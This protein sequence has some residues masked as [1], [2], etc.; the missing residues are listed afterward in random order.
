M[1]GAMSAAAASPIL[2]AADLCSFEQR[3]YVIARGAISQAQAARTAAEAWQ[4][5][6]RDPHDRSTWYSTTTGGSSAGLGALE[7]GRADMVE[8]WYN[9]TAPRVHQA[10]SQLW[11]SKRLWCSHDVV[12]IRPPEETG[13]VDG[14]RWEEA[15]AAALHWD[16]GELYNCQP[17]SAHVRSVRDAVGPLSF[18][19][20]GI[21]Y[22][23]DTPPEHGALCLVP[24]FHRRLDGWLESLPRGSTPMEQLAVAELRGCSLQRVGGK[25]GDLVIWNNT[26][27]HGATI[28][29]GDAPRMVQY[30]TMVP[31]AADQDE[32]SQE[33]LLQPVRGS[34][35]S[36]RIKLWET[37]LRS[38]AHPA[39][40][41]PVARR[42]IGVD[43]WGGKEREGFDGLAADWRAADAV[44]AARL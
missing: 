36:D 25:A 17:P 22:L 44:A 34:F 26:M 37:H 41:S 43:A 24:G 7:A 33:Q 5:S 40:L 4:V 39:V 31:A 15:A 16:R 13:R 8:P 18:G 29:M 1:S 2:S 28:N 11:R 12:G 32:R 14:A 23:T 10:F 38:A 27:P 20:Q 35:R 19:L 9:R 6:G 21:L 42:I 3:G 30:I